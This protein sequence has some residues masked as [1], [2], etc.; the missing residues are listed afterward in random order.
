[1]IDCYDDNFEPTKNQMTLRVSTY[2]DGDW[3]AV[4]LY[5]SDM[6]RLNTNEFW[7]K[8]HDNH[9]THIASCVKAG[10]MTYVPG[11]EARSGYASYKVARIL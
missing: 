8:T 3:L 1:M 11:K 2:I 5:D 4:V 10:L 7:Y 6:N 9:P